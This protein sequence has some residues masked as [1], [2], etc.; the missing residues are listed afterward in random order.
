MIISRINYIFV[1]DAAA[2]KTFGISQSIPAENTGSGRDL[3][4]LLSGLGCYMQGHFP[5]VLVTK[6]IDASDLQADEDYFKNSTLSET[7]GLE[8][9]LRF[10][11]TTY[12]Q[13]LQ[14]SNILTRGSVM[15][16]KRA[17]TDKRRAK[18]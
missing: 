11:D 7:E 6:V 13:L 3:K 17:G 2:I 5:A 16:N 8:L 4:Q 18:A 15:T 14:P 12:D 9:C 1:T 10:L